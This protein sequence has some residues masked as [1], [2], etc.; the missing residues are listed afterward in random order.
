MEEG[1]GEELDPLSGVRVVAALELVLALTRLVVTVLVLLA[2]V[3]AVDVEDSDEVVGVGVDDGPNTMGPELRSWPRMLKDGLLAPKP[4]TVPGRRL[5]QQGPAE[6][7]FS[8]TGNVALYAAA[9]FLNAVDIWISTQQV[10]S[11]QRREGMLPSV[12]LPSPLLHQRYRL[13]VGKGLVYVTLT[14][15]ILLYIWSFVG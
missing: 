4:A 7:R 5:N 14:V 9:L 12:I 1:V 3:A 11:H 2:D 8:N 13:G 15:S 10:D 6:V